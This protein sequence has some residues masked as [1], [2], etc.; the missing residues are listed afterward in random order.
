MSKHTHFVVHL[1]NMYLPHKYRIC[2]ERVLRERES[3]C[4]CV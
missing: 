2:T 4:V 1:D 3:V